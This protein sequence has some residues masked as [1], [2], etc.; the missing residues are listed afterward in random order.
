[1]NT[2][3]SIAIQPVLGGFIVSY[4]RRDSTPEGIEHVQEVTTSL[5][6]AMRIAKAA[7][8][9]FSLVTKDKAEAE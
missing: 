7:L 3:N 5:G 2:Y 1:M 6:K 8:E 9:E 4:P